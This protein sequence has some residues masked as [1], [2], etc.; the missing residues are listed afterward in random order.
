MLVPLSLVRYGGEVASD[1][2]Q[3]NIARWHSKCCTLS[4]IYYQQA[5]TGRLMGLEPTTSRATTWHSNRL[6][7]SRH[8][9]REH[10]PRTWEAPISVLQPVEYAKMIARPR[11]EVKG[12]E[13]IPAQTA[14]GERR[15]G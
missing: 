14:S 9:R 10:L 2:K 1:S 6:S 7:Y 5:S 8:T 3:A 4:A 12:A 15:N 11:L 13:E